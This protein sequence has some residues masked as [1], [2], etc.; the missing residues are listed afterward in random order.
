MFQ[1]HSQLKHSLKNVDISMY[2]KCY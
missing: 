1:L 2:L